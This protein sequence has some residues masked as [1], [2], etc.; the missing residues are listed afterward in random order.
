M[1]F[2]YAGD[3]KASDLAEV[4]FLVSDTDPSRPLLS[5][6][7]VTY[8]IDKWTPLYGSNSLNAAVCAEIIAGKFASE[9]SVSADGVS[10]SMSEAQQ[11]YNLLAE[12]LRDQYKQEQAMASPLFDGVLFDL[13]WDATIKPLVF[14]TGFMDNYLAGRQDYGDYAPSEYPQYLEPTNPGY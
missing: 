12:S 13:T 10:V 11:K 8:V 3:P 5:D 6:A 2:T 9:V 14:G 7:E 1:T 4:R